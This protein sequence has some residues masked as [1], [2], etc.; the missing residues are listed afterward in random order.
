MAAHY[1]MIVI[2]G[3]IAGGSAAY[4][5]AAAGA[6]RILLLEAGS[7]LGAE[8]SR[9]GAGI[10]NAH[11]AESP[12]GPFADLCFSAL[13]YY[14]EFA[15][16]LA[17]ETGIEVELLDWGVLDLLRDEPDRQLSR[18]RCEWLDARGARYERLRASDLRSRVPAAAGSFEE[19]V[20][21]SGDKHVNNDRLIDALEAA[22]VKRGVEI[23]L[24]ARVSGIAVEK[25]RAAG[26]VVDG[27]WIGAGAVVIAAGSWS[28]EIAKGLGRELPLQP[29][30]GQMV[31][32][33]P[34][35]PLLRHVL[36]AKLHYLVPRKRGE[37]LAGT[38]FELVGFNRETTAEGIA[39]IKREAAAICPVLAKLEIERA[40]AGLRPYCEDAQPIVGP[41]ASTPGVF[42]MTGHSRKGLLLGPL[43]GKCLAEM[44]TTGHSSPLLQCADPRR[45][46]L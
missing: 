40:W 2:G 8:S 39:S 26:V 34:K 15:A 32:Y 27:V 43:T 30:R 22:C 36:T 33:R 19:A 12:P 41:C 11:F 5:L 37:I 1:E 18:A 4:H 31:S 28:G 7:R 17:E 13:D 24:G 10:L 14:P 44:I 45:F 20:L 29:A 35:R 42:F 6:G 25:G 3:G 9:A 16:S 23:R 38:T 21:Y 46:G